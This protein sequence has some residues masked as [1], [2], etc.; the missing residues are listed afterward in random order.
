MHTDPG[1]CFAFNSSL[2]SFCLLSFSAVQAQE[3]ILH[4]AKFAIC[5]QLQ[6]NSVSVLVA[7]WPRAVS[8]LS[9]AVAMG[10]FCS[11]PY[12]HPFSGQKANAFIVRCHWKYQLLTKDADTQNSNIM[13]AI[14]IYTVPLQQK[15]HG[16]FITT[17]MWLVYSPHQG[18]LPALLQLTDNPAISTSNSSSFCLAGVPLTCVSHSQASGQS[19]PVA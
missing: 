9:L 7:N 1:D 12:K 2:S 3:N 4:L 13:P 19:S 5:C 11:L 17:V 8:M 15:A 16:L 6:I 10:N 18:F 14:D